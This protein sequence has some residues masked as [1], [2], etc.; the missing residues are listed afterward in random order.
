M[1]RV[2]VVGGGSIG[3]RHLRNLAGLSRGPVALVEPTEEGRSGHGVDAPSFATLDE[4]LAW[5]PDAV[6]I[7]SPT[8]HHVDQSLAAA[9]DGCHLFVEKPLSYR[10]HQVDELVAI[11]SNQVTMVACNL[12][13][14]PVNQQVARLLEAGR[15]GRPISA[16]LWT[17]SYLPRWRPASDYRESYSASAESGGAILDCIHELDLAHW[18]LGPASVLASAHRP[19]TH[20]GL[21]TDGLAEILL[22]HDAGPLASVHLNYLQR[23]TSRGVTIVGE[24]GTLE[25]RLG[26]GDVEVFG[27]D[28]ERTEVFST[29]SDWEA[30][31]VYIDEMAHFLDAISTESPTMNPLAGGAAVLELALAAREQ[32]LWGDQ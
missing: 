5:G 23:N 7:A 27:P 4:G 6:V 22:R 29:P 11:A 14:H 2:L 8:A 24:E 32:N 17:G 3:R 15:I 20:L 31:Q 18:L 13:F 16:R 19:A 1:T 25:G 12:R 10:R 30:N 28:G 26:S 21:E 9:R